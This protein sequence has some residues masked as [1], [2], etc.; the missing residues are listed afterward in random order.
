VKHL[1]HQNLIRGDD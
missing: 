1:K